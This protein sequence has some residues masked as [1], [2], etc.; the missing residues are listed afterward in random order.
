[1]I[2]SL[3]LTLPLCALLWGCQTTTKQNACDGFSRLTPSLGTSVTILRTDR[4]FANQVASHNKFGKSQ[5][6][7]K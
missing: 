3:L 6:C 1:M 5:G 2:R 7:W 4:P